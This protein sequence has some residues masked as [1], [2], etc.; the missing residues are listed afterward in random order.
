M[1]RYIIPSVGSQLKLERRCPHCERNDGNIHSSI[2]Y[3]RISDTKVTAI[4]QHRMKCPWC[5]TMLS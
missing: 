1:V 3:R 5:R 2:R 4:A